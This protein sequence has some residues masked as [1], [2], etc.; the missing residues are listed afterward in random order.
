MQKLSDI[1]TAACRT[2]SCRQKQ[3]RL[4]RMLWWSRNVTKS[5][6]EA[7]VW[8]WIY[9]ALHQ[10]SPPVGTIRRRGWRHAVR[11]NMWG[12]DSVCDHVMHHLPLYTHNNAA[13]MSFLCATKAASI[14]L[15]GGKA[16]QRRGC[17]CV[18]W[19]WCSLFDRFNGFWS[20]R[21]TKILSPV[22]FFFLNPWLVATH[23][24][25]DETCPEAHQRALCPAEITQWW[26]QKVYYLF[27]Q[28]AAKY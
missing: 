24:K 14:M 27:K 25:T 5:H 23:Q 3:K 20:H 21:P 1:C 19:Q 4:Q 8:R 18:R 22:S 9:A 7:F 11:T 12:S 26:K 6:A 15:M 17:Q 10:T 28:K 13:V 2:R 16:K